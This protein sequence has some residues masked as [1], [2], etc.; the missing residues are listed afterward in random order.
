M[1]AALFSGLIFFFFFA[2]KIERPALRQLLSYYSPTHL[3]PSQLIL[4][5]LAATAGVPVGT[6]AAPGAV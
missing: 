3:D 2:I 5:P 6:P 4:T 1:S